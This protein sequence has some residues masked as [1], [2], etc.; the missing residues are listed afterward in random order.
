MRICIPIL[1]PMFL[2]VVMVL[3]P[4]RARLN[5]SDFTTFTDVAAKAGLTQP[6]V[7]GGIDRKRYIIET[8][9]C[10]VAF[11]DYDQDGWMDL[12]VLSG[13]RLEGFPKEKEPTTRLYRNNRNGTFTDITAGSGLERVGW[14]SGVSIGDYDNDGDDD[15]FIT[16]W[17]TNALFRNDGKGKFTDVTTRAGLGFEGVR[18]GSGS[19][20]IDYDRDGDLDLFVANYLTF[21]MSAAP[22]P[23]KGVNCVWKGIP[24]NCGPKGLPFARNWL[25]RN[26]GDSTFSDVSEQAGITRVHGRYPMSVAAADFNEDGLTDL[27]VA[28]DS[29]ASILYRNGGDGTFSD[30]ALE[31]GLAFNEDGNVQAGMGLGIGD[32]NRD[33]KLDIFKTHFADDTP[34]LYRNMGRGAF[35]DVTTAAGFISATRFVSWGAGMQDLDNDSWPDIL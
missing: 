33:G 30:V 7:Y 13:T 24:V 8:N 28:C 5:D 16:Y 1:L 20:F 19:S 14:A 17:G 2:I 22:E 6:T 10:G 12:L 26:N 35:E 29:T 32:F 23:G 31:N 9:G 15:L 25:Y 18:W 21:D 4:A 34:I 11:Y 3:I 27:Y